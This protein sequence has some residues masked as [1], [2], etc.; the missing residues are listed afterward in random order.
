MPVTVTDP[1]AAQVITVRAPHG[2]LG[3]WKF[4]F[5]VGDRTILL[6]YGV[7]IFKIEEGILGLPTWILR[8]LSSPRFSWEVLELAM[9][10]VHHPHPGRGCARYIPGWTG[11]LH[12]SCTA[13]WPLPS[14]ALWTKTVS[15]R[16]RIPLSN[17]MYSNRWSWDLSSWDSDSS[18]CNE[19][20][21]MPL[22][23]VWGGDI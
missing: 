3:N 16:D 11:C 8:T 9:R 13:R 5:I 22:L 2:I 17:I 21:R 14:S 4:S 10:R 20:H 1:G 23:S 18:M 19:P 7:P 6:L 15:C 12:G